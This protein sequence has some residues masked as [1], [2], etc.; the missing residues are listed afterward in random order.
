MHCEKLSWNC[1]HQPP[2]LLRRCQKYHTLARPSPSP[3]DF[4][5]CYVIW[6]WTSLW[7]WS[8]FYGFQ[9]PIQV[10]KPPYF[11]QVGTVSSLS[12]SSILNQVSIYRERLKD[13][14]QTPE[15]QTEEQR[16]KGESSA[17][18]SVW[19]RKDFKIKGC[20]GLLCAQK[21]LP[22]VTDNHCGSSHPI[23][24]LLW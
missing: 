15:H 10:F 2:S 4:N 14:I 8:V 11:P 13:W 18:D 21:M 24:S 16:S 12:C 3:L 6:V 23:K 1:H 22:I 9:I 5:K 19:F 7:S 20:R 17:I